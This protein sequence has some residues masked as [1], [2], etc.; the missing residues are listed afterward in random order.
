MKEQNINPFAVIENENLISGGLNE[1]GDEE[2]VTEMHVT[3]EV[4]D[5]DNGDNGE[6]IQGREFDYKGKKK[7]QSGH[8]ESSKD[9]Q[10]E[11]SSQHLFTRLTKSVGR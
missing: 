11:K 8:K 9:E 4:N 6:G 3:R 1:E 7:A 2:C 5:H 10:S